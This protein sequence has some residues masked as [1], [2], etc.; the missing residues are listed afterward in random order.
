MFEIETD[1]G[2]HM[3]LYTTGEVAKILNL[4][5]SNGKSIGRTKMFKILR[6]NKVLLRDNSP[7]QYYITM[8]LA[9]LHKPLKRWKRYTMPCFTE[10]GLN[11]L[12][13]AFKQ[14]KLQ[15]VQESKPL[16]KNIVNI[17]DIM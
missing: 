7:N 14:G 6:W 4:K 5:D 8:G 3:V 15:L 16:V 11:Y 12:E 10:R 9:M 1:E 2:H 13:N 17:N